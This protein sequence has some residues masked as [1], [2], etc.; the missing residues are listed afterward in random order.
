L[1]LA[2]GPPI[3]SGLTETFGEEKAYR[4]PVISMFFGIIVSLYFHDDTR[5]HRPHIH[6]KY[7]DDEGNRL[8]SS[9]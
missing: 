4:M 6:A 9:R 3:P 1:Y 8:R 5:H 2:S 7:Q